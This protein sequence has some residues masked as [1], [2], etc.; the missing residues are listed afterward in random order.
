MK[1]IP[2]SLKEACKFVAIFHRHNNPPVGGL[3]AIGLEY[4][5]LIIGCAIVGRPVARALDD[6]YTTEVTR[7]CT[8]PDA[9]KGAVSKLY[10]ACQK[11][12][13]A[14]G[15]QRCITYTLQT[16]SGASLLG[17]GW[18]QTAFLEPR[19]GWDCPSRR[20][21]QGTVDRQA[22]IR[23]EAIIKEVDR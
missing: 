23:W 18:V 7:V 13:A 9:P 12:S 20:R 16:E 17:A 14:L 21:G 4:E 3:F 10:R 15:Y 2:M 22:K 11:A 19:G 1:L 8:S 5:G 6:G